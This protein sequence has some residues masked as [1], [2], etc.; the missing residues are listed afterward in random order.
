M[1]NM[2]V[3]ALRVNIQYDYRRTYTTHQTILHKKLLIL[4]NNRYFQYSI[5]S[6]N[7]KEGK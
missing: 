3:K 5:Y 7:L 6:K 1:T 4:I 2:A